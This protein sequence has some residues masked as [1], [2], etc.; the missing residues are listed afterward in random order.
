MNSRCF[1]NGLK[2]VKYMQFL[3]VKR[4]KALVKNPGPTTVFRVDIDRHRG[5]TITK[6][7][8][9][10]T[11]WV[12]GKTAMSWPVVHVMRHW[13]KAKVFRFVQG[14]WDPIIDSV[15]SPH[16]AYKYFEKTDD[17]GVR[18]VQREV[19]PSSDHDAVLGLVMDVLLSSTTCVFIP[20]EDVC[21][22][23]SDGTDAELRSLLKDAN[24]H[25][26]SILGDSPSGAVVLSNYLLV[27]GASACADAM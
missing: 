22:L 25:V 1:M 24:I 26:Y 6:A 11:P 17:R 15:F 10:N 20:A 18:S 4:Y 16:K 23:G 27:C 13:P 12:T 14:E 19:H 2:V 3:Q 21:G 8:P 5:A 7:V 9:G